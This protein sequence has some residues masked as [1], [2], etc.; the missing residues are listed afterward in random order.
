[1]KQNESAVRTVAETV[2]AKKSLS[3]GIVLAV[4]AAVVASLC[5]PLLLGRIIDAMTAG[6]SVPVIWA[7][8]YF[9]LLALE[10]LMEAARECG[11][12]VFGQTM[13]H[14]LRSRL[15]G[16]LTRLSADE[17]SR[18]EPGA[19]AA[20]FV[21]DVDTVES[22]FTGGIAG[23]AADA[24]KIVGIL[25]VIGLR[26]RGLAL[27]LVV[28]LPFLF[29]FTRRVQRGMLAA[30]MANRRAVSRASSLVPETIR[31]IRTIRCL[32]KEDYM[33]ARYDEAIESGYRA[34]EKT[35]FY[36]A[37][38]SPVIL[39]L[40]AIVVAVVMLLSASGNARV[41]TLF[42]MSAG[43]AVAVMN[44]I[45]QIFSPIESLGM[46][47]QTIQS[48]VAGV[49]RIDEFFSLP[50]CEACSES[51]EK[52]ATDAA[53]ELRHVTF[54]YDD[55]IV[56]KD[57]NLRVRPGERVTLVGRTGAGK[58]TVFKLLMGLYRPKSGEVLVGGMLSTAMVE[59]ERRRAIGYVEQT[60]H[61]VPGTVRDQIT[62]YDDAL[63]DI[64]VHRAAALVGLD[65]H[66][67]S[68][69][70]GYDT[71]CTADLFSQGEWQL[72]SIA[73]AAVADPKIMLLD[74][75]TANLDAETE[76]RVLRALERASEGRTVI[77][78]SHRDTGSVGSGLSRRVSIDSI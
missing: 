41:L 6:E 4:G 38:Y 50:E 2:C 26:N 12:T 31:C 15:M 27:V 49:K 57:M 56:L 25:A 20:R 44:Y 14:A 63:D 67:E 68:L 65:T 3:A 42:G 69:P 45:S 1:M 30:Q 77:S 58:S 18:Q 78:I 60:F 24:C 8:G 17:L 61:A 71:P 59:G 55:H 76:R 40:N 22:L 75:I 51:R 23:M 53:V 39:T 34:M 28:L 16:K 73:R 19:V 32:S 72:I 35:N 7:V 5:P 66:I 29:L 46:E 9:A 13:T 62:L 70:Q 48:A 21:S 10:G 74:E 54:G 64:A 47:I 33:A 52:V 11:L 36:D 37:I 43:T